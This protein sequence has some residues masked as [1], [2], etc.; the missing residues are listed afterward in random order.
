[1]G[2]EELRDDQTIVALG[3][4]QS[5]RCLAFASPRLRGDAAFMLKAVGISTEALRHA[6]PAL[7]ADEAFLRQARSAYAVGRH[8]QAVQLDGLALQH[9]AEDQV[10]RPL[11]LLA[12][13]QDWRALAYVGEQRG[14]R[15]VA[16]E[17]LR[18]HHGALELCGEQLR[19]DEELVFEAARHRPD[20][21]GRSALVQ[22][23]LTRA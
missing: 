7:L 21:L 5:W 4:K 1:M 20:V 16:L 14:D 10:D 22:G 13:R 12:V 18:Q 9:V 6:A 23:S 3:L 8:G 2:A 15:A 17:A 11:A 19:R